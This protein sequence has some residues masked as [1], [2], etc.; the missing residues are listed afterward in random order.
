[1]RS[2]IVWIQRLNFSRNFLLQNRSLHGY[3]R[4][5]SFEQ[6]AHWIQG[7]R[8]TMQFIEKQR[9]NNADSLSRDKLT[10]TTF[11]SK[12]RLE[13]PK[14]LSPPLSL[15]HEIF[16]EVSEII[17]IKRLIDIWFSLFDPAWFVRINFFNLIS[18]MFS[19]FENKVAA[20]VLD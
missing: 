4:R 6:F 16:N 12:L 10:L 8:W 15:K 3:L 20:P 5:L 19:G 7:R 9:K 18:R 1:M 13:S 2:F 14:A 17:W 11:T